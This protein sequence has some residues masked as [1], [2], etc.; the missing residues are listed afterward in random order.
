VKERMKAAAAKASGIHIRKERSELRK[1]QL[2]FDRATSEA[3]GSEVVFL[4]APVQ[5]RVFLAGQETARLG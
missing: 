5:R 3:S 2:D 4:G 1:P